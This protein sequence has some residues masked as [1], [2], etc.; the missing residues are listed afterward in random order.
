MVGF[1][2]NTAPQYDSGFLGD[3]A[4]IVLAWPAPSLQSIVT[5]ASGAAGGGRVSASVTALP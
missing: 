3:G 1:F 2:R 4:D 5:V